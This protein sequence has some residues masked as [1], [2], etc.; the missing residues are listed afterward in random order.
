ME[1]KISAKNSKLTKLCENAC[2]HVL[3]D[4]QT[5]LSGFLMFSSNLVMFAK[6]REK[7]LRISIF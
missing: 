7:F 3:S 6:S 2:K 5:L 1:I 4:L